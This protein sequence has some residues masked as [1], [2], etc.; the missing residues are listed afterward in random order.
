MAQFLKPDDNVA[1]LLKGALK[2]GTMLPT[3][4]QQDLIRL[5]PQ[6]GLYL[7]KKDEYVIYQGEES[8]DIFIVQTGKV[9]ITQ[10]MGTMGSQLAALGPGEIF[11]EMALV[12]DGV[13]VA[14]AIA[15][16]DSRVFRL[17][18]PDIEG[19]MAD[20]RPLGEHLKNLAQLRAG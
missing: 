17:S 7:Y 19:L 3:M 10:T 16:E 5:F 18:E 8:K 9:A 20:N 4:S 2:I 14:S 11:G 6:S 15:A 1:E 13:R 12:R